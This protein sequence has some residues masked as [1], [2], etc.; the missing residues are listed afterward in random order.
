MF[1]HIGGGMH[2]KFLIPNIENLST[3]FGINLQGI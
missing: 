2:S 1:L 3:I